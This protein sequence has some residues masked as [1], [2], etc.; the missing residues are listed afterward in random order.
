MGVHIYQP[1]IHAMTFMAEMNYMKLG[2]D[3]ID[4]L[5]KTPFLP[6]GTITEKQNIESIE[7]NN[8]HFSYNNIEVLK[9]LSL[10]IKANTLT[11][12]VGPSG[13][14]K[15]TLTRLI[16]R[17]WDVNSGE[18]LINGNNIKDYN[19]N[20]LM[21]MIS[22]VFQ[23]VYLFND[24]IYNN[25]RVGREDA[26]EAEIIEAAKLAQCHEFINSM[27]DKYQTMVGEGG[28]TLSGGE[29]QRISI[30]RA[31]LKDAPIIL[32]DEATAS[33]D[34]ENELFIQKA[35]NDLIRNKT[36]IIIAHRLNT[37]KNAD[38]IVVINQGEITEQGRHHELMKN[39]SL[40]KNLW[41]EQQKIKGWKF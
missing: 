12:L 19:S 4:T 29:K 34:P 10:K 9:G 20:N 5:I 22:I 3:R 18:I 6:E 32:L 39:N 40:Y 21:S 28:S 35:I 14:G 41:D 11:A 25:I 30:A 36:V 27:P 17:F 15:T 33:L 2:A 7:F 37:I 13:S 1:L 8:V 31:I 26:T 24:T 38:N 23:D 16:A